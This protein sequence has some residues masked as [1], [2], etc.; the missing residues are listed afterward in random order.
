MSALKRITSW[1]PA[2]DRRDADPSKNYGVSAMTLS[3]AVLGEKG[4]VELSIYTGWYLKH[5]RE[6]FA[7]KRLLS[8]TFMGR[9]LGYHSYRAQYAGQWSS[10]CCHLLGEERCFY[11]GSSLQAQE[12]TEYFLEHG[13]ESL[14]RKL[15]QLYK[16]Y[17]DGERI[18]TTATAGTEEE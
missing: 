13:D 11:E 12:L 8:D 6:E 16:Q 3:F 10:D 9:D 17:Y 1:I 7:E 14:F 4:A 5:V 15:E 2:T 18:E